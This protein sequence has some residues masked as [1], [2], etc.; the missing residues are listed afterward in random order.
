MPDS[1]ITA[2]VILAAGRSRRMGR[3]KFS[4]EI[5]SSEEGPSRTF[6]EKITLVFRKAGIETIGVVVNP[7]DEVTVSR[8]NEEKRLGLL[9]IINPVP[10]A[11]MI[12]SIRRARE[13]FSDRERLLISLVDVP[14][15]R[16]DAIK[17]MLQ[18][19]TADGVGILLPEYD[20][21]YGHPVL[22]TRSLYTLLD[23]SLPQGLKTIIREKPAMVERV[24]IEGRQ[25]RDIDTPEDY[26][27]FLASRIG[28]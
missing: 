26:R 17:T 12:E 7:S 16:P 10:E 14:T 19:E 13:A 23:D 21:G 4:L 22:I 27:R 18:Y 6:L 25:P 20:D 2:G 8:L 9:I 5:P 11:E 3:P 28:P 15:I 24:R 1:R